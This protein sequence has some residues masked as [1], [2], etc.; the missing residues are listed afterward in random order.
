M[1]R[2]LR[3]RESVS[4]AYRAESLPVPDMGGLEIEVIRAGE[5]LA[6]DQKRFVRRYCSPLQ[7]WYLLRLRGLGVG[8]L[9]LV[10]VGD[11]FVHYTF[12]TRAKWYRKE[13]PV[14]T[15]PRALLVGPCRTES[16]FRGR[17]IYPRV[18]QYVVN[19]LAGEGH[20]PFYMHVTPDNVASVRGIEKAGFTRCGAWA[21]THRMMG[22]LVTS[23]RVGD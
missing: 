15:E 5:C 20:G 3:N 23:R 7:L 14:I 22:L 13:L 6:T 12:V 16:A 1:R 4:I 21:A 18:L 19:R 2:L 11:Q 9:F 10:R 8:W 17:A